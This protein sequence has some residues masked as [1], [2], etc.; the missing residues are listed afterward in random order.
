[1]VAEGWGIGGSFRCVTVSVL[2]DEKLWSW[3]VLV[4]YNTARVSGTTTLYVTAV[5]PGV[6]AHNFSPCTQES[7]TGR[8]L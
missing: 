6:V 3:A 8:S 5:R 7:E 2:Q 1:M 4:L